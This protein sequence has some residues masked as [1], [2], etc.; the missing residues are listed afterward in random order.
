MTLN[1][2]VHAGWM[3][4]VSFLAGPGTFIFARLP[5]LAVRPAQTP[6]QWVLP[7]SQGCEVSLATNRVLI[8]VYY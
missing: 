8:P 6:I 4:D 2:S 5:R 7:L 1:G 3:I